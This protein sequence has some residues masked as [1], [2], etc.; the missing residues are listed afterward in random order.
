MIP[1]TRSFRRSDDKKA[2]DTFLLGVLGEQTRSQ[3]STQSAQV[4]LDNV[5]TLRGALLHDGAF[6]PAST[7]PLAAFELPYQTTTSE[8]SPFRCCS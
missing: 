7:V 1:T 2:L 5:S 3:L 4:L 6:P 8:V